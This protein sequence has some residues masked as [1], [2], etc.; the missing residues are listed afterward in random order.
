MD[1]NEEV[2][3]RFNGITI[4][5]VL[6]II[7]QSSRTISLY[8]SDLERRCYKLTFHERDRENI[9]KEYLK[10]V[11]KEG[12]EIKVR[13]RQRMLYTNNQKENSMHDKVWSRVV[14]EH[15]ATFETLA[16][17]TKK[18]EEIIN[19][20]VSFT[21]RKEYYL[22]IGKA[23]K[24][25][26]LLCGPAGTGKS[27]MIAAMANLLNYDVY[28]VELTSVR[29]N[30]ELRKLLINTS[31]KSIVVIEDIDCSL[32]LTGHRNKEKENDQILKYAKEDSKTKVTLS[33]LLNFIDGL[34]SSCV[35]ERIIVFTTNHVDKLD[36]ALI[37]RGRMDMHIELSYCKFEAFKVLAKN[38]LD[39]DSHDFFGT[40]DKLMEETNI[41]PADVS[42]YLMLKT[43]ENV[44]SCLERLIQVLETA[45]EDAMLQ[46][47][48]EA[49]EKKTLT[50]EQI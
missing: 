6:M 16:M 40:I 14:F 19:D 24:R 28:D 23:W 13:N 45:K 26:Y 9:T 29:D 46:S 33:G 20:L 31:S 27:T 49:E 15:P 47:Q 22:K 39:I 37:R 30:T 3:D 11:L 17:D 10:H 5:W 4:S 42:E 34:W 36:P 21:K 2:L 25:G 32:N 7:Q 38:F 50:K 44:T 48:K 8:S 41:T 1:K 12:K 18:K 35:G 43:T